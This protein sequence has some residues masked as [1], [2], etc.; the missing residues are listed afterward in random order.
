MAAP[1]SV[2]ILLLMTRVCFN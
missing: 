1:L 2:Y